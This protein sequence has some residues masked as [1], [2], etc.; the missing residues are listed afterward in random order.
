[1][2]RRLGAGEIAH[3]LSQMRIPTRRDERVNDCVK[4]LKRRGYG[5]RAPSK[6]C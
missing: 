1:M 3:R 2:G 6:R 5:P 4:K